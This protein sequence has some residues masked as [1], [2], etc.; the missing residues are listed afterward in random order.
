MLN[1][2]TPASA[3]ATHY[4]WGVSRHFNQDDEELTRLIHA[5][6]ERTF[7]EDTEVLE[8]QHALIK[9]DP[10]DHPMINV[11]ADRGVVLARRLFEE[12]LAAEQAS[13]ISG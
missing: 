8:T 7:D 13:G 11:A 12:R 1:A 6:T 9:S 10:P 5:A 4:F 2:I 3:D